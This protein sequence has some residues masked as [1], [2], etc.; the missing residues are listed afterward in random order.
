MKWIDH[1]VVQFTPLCENYFYNTE[2]KYNGTIK[3]SEGGIMSV[4][5]RINGYLMIWTIN[6]QLLMLIISDFS[7]M[8]NFSHFTPKY[9]VNGQL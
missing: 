6:R 9:Y 1:H 4:E 8:D 5:K 3:R 2:Y 7:A